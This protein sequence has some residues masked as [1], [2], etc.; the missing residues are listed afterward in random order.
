MYVPLLICIC[1]N[2][3]MH[4]SPSIHPLTYT[5]SYVDGYQLIVVYSQHLVKYLWRRQTHD[6]QCTCTHYTTVSYS[7]HQ[8]LCIHT[9]TRIS[10]VLELP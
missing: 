6:Y 5:Q 8:P 7:Y 2:Q 10:A 3:L 4:I 1:P 9:H